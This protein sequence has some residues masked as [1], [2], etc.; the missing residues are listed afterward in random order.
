MTCWTYN[1]LFAAHEKMTTKD[2]MKNIWI[3]KLKRN[4]STTCFADHS[5]ASFVSA[6]K[7]LLGYLGTNGIHRVEGTNGTRKKTLVDIV[8]DFFDEQRWRMDFF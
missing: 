5:R 3:Q 4:F 8:A 2:F 6:A 7:G 1:R